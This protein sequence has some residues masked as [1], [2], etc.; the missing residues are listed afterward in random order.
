MPYLSNMKETLETVKGF[1]FNKEVLF[2]T[3]KLGL[4]GQSEVWTMHL[5]GEQQSW[6]VLPKSPPD[7]RNLEK[8]KK[9]KFRVLM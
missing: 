4:K 7:E 5:H 1:D 8:R 9:K 2:L 6:L 3:D